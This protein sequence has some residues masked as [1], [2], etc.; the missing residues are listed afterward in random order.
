MSNLQGWGC[1]HA[2]DVC[3]C[4]C[5]C[6]CVCVGMAAFSTQLSA[7]GLQGSESQLLWGHPRSLAAFQL[8]SLGSNSKNKQDSRKNVS[9]IINQPIIIINLCTLKWV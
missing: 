1:L 3:E 5:V 9:S 7:R 4:V 2:V 8:A 6:A